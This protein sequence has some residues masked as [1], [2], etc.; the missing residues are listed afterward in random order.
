MDVRKATN[1]V[2]EMID[3]GMLD[4]EEVVMMCLKWMSEDDVKAMCEANEIDLDVEIE[5][6]EDDE[7]EEE[8]EL[9]Y[10]MTAAELRRRQWYS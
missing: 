2:L 6:E 9:P 3:E 8:D 4:A 1:K 7:V 5:D 10:G